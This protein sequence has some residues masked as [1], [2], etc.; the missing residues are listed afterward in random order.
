MKLAYEIF[1]KEGYGVELGEKY[2]ESAELVKF[3]LTRLENG[4]EW[5]EKGMLEEERLKIKHVNARKVEIREA[6][7]VEMSVGEIVEIEV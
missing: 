4:R 3:E 7:I 1:Q 5:A 2:L 6:A